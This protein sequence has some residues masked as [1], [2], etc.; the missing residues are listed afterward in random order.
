MVIDPT[1]ATLV[2]RQDL[3]ER[4]SIVRVRPDGGQVPPFKPGQ[5]LMLGLPKPA[6]PEHDPARRP[7]RS[8]R[9]PMTRRAYSMASSPLETETLEFFVVLIE[10]GKLT[11]RLWDLR[12]GERLWMDREVKGE[13]TLDAVPPGRDLVMISTGTGIAPFLSMLRTY[14]GQQRWRRLAVV[15][16]VRYVSDLGYREELEGLSRVEPSVCYV[17]MVSRPSPADGWRGLCG[18]VTTLL[19]D[20][21][22]AQHIGIRLDPAASHVFLCGNPAM[23]DEMERGLQARGFRTHSAE[24]PGN[25]HLERYW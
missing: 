25:L 22:C 19:G 12:V 2:A 8:G 14:R 4:L 16:G 1:N 20:D 23:I 17:P 13:F 24:T 18:R 7:R 11:P 3:N 10:E 5:F 9:V 6:R 21:L 15:N